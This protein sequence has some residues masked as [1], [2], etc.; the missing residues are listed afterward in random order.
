MSRRKSGDSPVLTKGHHTS[1]PASPGTGVGPLTTQLGKTA[2]WWVSDWCSSLAGALPA[3]HS[4]WRLR[5]PMGGW[6]GHP[7]PLVWVW[8]CTPWPPTHTHHRPLALL[9]GSKQPGY[10]LERQ[11]CTLGC[12]HA[13]QGGLPVPTYQDPLSHK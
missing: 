7:W 5:R 8:L 9:S 3:L 2:S 6:V 10:P 4:M 1:V 11:P 13:R 12:P